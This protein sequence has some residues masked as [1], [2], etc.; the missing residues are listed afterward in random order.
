MV[1]LWG[2]YEKLIKRKVDKCNNM[3]NMFFKFVNFFSVY[4]KLKRKFL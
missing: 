3:I 1:F 2:N 4:I